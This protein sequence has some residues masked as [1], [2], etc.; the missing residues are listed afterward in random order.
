VQFSVATHACVQGPLPR[1]SASMT[2]EA[3]RPR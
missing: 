1:T 3:R 2:A